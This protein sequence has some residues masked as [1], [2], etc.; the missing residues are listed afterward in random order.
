MKN[1]FFSG[2]NIVEFYAEYITDLNIL[3]RLLTVSKDRLWVKIIDEFNSIKTI[4]T[5]INLLN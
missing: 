4:N 3:F 1:D 2:K 5:L